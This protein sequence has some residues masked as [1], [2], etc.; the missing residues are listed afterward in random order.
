MATLLKRAIFSMSPEQEAH[1]KQLKREKFFD[2]PFS[3]MYRQIMTV[4]IEV[5]MS[6]QSDQIKPSA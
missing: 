5:L 2:V 1:I 4:G 3:E 6:R